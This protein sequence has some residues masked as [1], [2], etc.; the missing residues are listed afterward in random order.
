MKQ[1]T[2]VFKDMDEKDADQGALPQKA[3]KKE[4]PAKQSQQQTKKQDRSQQKEK[5]GKMHNIFM[6]VNTSTY[7]SPPKT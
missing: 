7:P 2:L 6:L 3:E 1:E 5:Q 4:K